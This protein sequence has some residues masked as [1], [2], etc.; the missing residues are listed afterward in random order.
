MTAPLP[1]IYNGDGEFSTPRGWAARADATF[2]IGAV[3]QMTAIEQRSAKQHARYFAMV[4]EYW[5]TL[6]ETLAGLYPSSEHLRKA[7]L[8]HTGF[9]DERN[10]V[11][12]N[13][14]AALECAAM[15]GEGDTY[16]VV[17]VNGN[18]CRVWRAHSQNTRAMDKERF[19]ASSD[20][21][22]HWIETD[23]LGMYKETA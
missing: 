8:C 7:A 18:V 14:R 15:A 10:I 20:S 16:A 3:Y 1:L 13:N 6:P 19:K 21:V 23:L 9:C 12:A 17:S 11:C 22:L 5:A 2:V 4:N